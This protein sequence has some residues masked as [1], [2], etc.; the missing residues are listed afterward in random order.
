MNLRL[1]R[2][3]SAQETTLGVLFVDGV[4]RAFT[5]EDQIREIPG[6]PVK[7]WKVYGVTAIPA[8]RYRVQVTWSPRFQRRLPELFD[9]PG[10]TGIRIHPL[11]TARESEGCIGCGLQRA[12]ASIQQS[13]MAQQVVQDL[14]ELAESRGDEVWIDIENPPSYTT[15]KES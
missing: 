9:V 14:I 5:L 8:G 6:R 4:F 12:G 2:E 13:R 3:P 1:I 11:N 15:A 7:D 10:Y